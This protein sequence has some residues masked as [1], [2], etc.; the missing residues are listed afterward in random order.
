MPQNW[1]VGQG[2][3]GPLQGTV[4]TTPGQTPPAQQPPA[5]QPPAQNP[6]D[7]MQSFYG[8]GGPNVG[9]NA[10]TPWASWFYSGGTN[11]QGWQTLGGGPDT[12]F[13]GNFQQ[14]LNGGASPT[15][16]TP[17]GAGDMAAAAQPYTDAAYQQSMRELQPQ[18]DQQNA[19]FQQ[20]MI[21]QGI[22][23]GSAAY[24]QAANQ[25]SMNQNDAMAQARD[26]A[27]QQGLAAQG[28]GFQQGLSQSQLAAQLAG[29]LLGSNTSIANQQLGGNAS[30][31]NALLGGNS[32]IAQQLIGANASI[33]GAN[34][35]A[36]ASR[37]NGM[38]NYNLGMAQ[39][40]QQGQQ[41]DFNNLMS[42][43]GLGMGA[44]QY[45]NGLLNQNQSNAMQFF[46]YMPQGSNSNIDVTGPYGQQYNSQMNQ[47]GY[48]NQQANSENQAGM[49]AL[50][51]AM[52]L[53]D[54]NAKEGC[55]ELNIN[56][57]EVIRLLPV[58]RWRYKGQD[59]D[60]IG[61]YA[62]D[63]HRLLGLR[64]SKTISVIDLLG[65]MLKVAKDQTA[66]IDHLEQELARRAA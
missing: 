3:Q 57:E 42:M 17:T 56:C 49:T 53:C 36:A 65:F 47:W 44:D 8:Q 11:P 61:T 30:I 4:P 7:P 64:P 37:A 24:T 15:T 2:Y 48:Q 22:A 26:Q 18:M 12:S 29:Q 21:N 39:L 5:A 62:Q 33:Q 23:P 9:P 35:A 40:Q 28:Q 54:R 59:I 20:Q 32:G 43:L 31:M 16:V 60:H 55:E 45:N 58:E 34:A 63:F 41:S 38:N 66:R 46:G 50:M 19:A 10:M 51:Y 14:M 13:L 6:V 25:L 27:M 52:M 1:V